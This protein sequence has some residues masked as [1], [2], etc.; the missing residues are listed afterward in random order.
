LTSNLKT[1]NITAI[2]ND[3][4]SVKVIGLV[5]EDGSRNWRA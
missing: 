4:M 3:D 1:L 2:L 5:F